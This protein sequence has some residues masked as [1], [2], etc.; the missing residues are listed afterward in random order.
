M[1]HFAEIENGIVVNVIVAEEDFIKQLPGKWVQTSYNT[2]GGVH[3]G[4]DGKP[5]NGVPLRKNYAGIGYIYD[6]ELDAFYQPQP[7]P[8]YYLDKESCTWKLKDKAIEE[9]K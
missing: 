9:T 2:V 3:Y 7:G 5:D 1:S 6:E 4:P 8:D